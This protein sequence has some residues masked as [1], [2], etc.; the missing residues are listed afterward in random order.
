[1]Q[2]FRKSEAFS[3]ITFFS[4]RRFVM[5]RKLIGVMLVVV[6]VVACVSQVQASA[7]AVVDYSFE[8]TSAAASPYY[9]IMPTNAS[10]AAGAG[11][12]TGPV[13]VGPTG[14]WV[15]RGAYNDWTN[16]DSN[17]YA[18]MYS[19]NAD[20]LWT[21]QVLTNT[22]Q[23]GLTYDLSMLCGRNYDVTQSNVYIELGYKDETGLHSIGGAA[24]NSFVEGTLPLG[25]LPADTAMVDKSATVTVGASDAW[26]GKNI[27]IRFGY[28]GSS[29]DTRLC[30]D[31]VRLDVTPE[32]SSIVLI[33]SALVGLLAYAWRKRK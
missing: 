17:Q 26:V 22:Y 5:N 14:L 9:V 13:Q 30:V 20:S 32:P 21:G 11:W 33:A 23:A 8:D 3:S 27:L 29:G 2:V 16:L 19:K 6:A 18:A 1:M 15:L 25:N 24:K 12:A 4:L 10:P 7:I 31:N 28:T